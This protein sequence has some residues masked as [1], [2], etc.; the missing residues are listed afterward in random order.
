MAKQILQL[1]IGDAVDDWL[2]GRIQWLRKEEVVASGIKWVKQVSY[3]RF[4]AKWS[5]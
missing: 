1:G 4:W 2:I 5:M 3:C